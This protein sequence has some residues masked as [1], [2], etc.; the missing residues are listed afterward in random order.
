MNKN[1]YK[2]FGFVNIVTFPCLLIVSN[3]YIKKY[4]KNEIYL[5]GC[6]CKN[7]EYCENCG[8]T[9]SGYGYD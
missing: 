4:G 9:I 3:N 5:K 6:N 8:G 2:L 7:N 1:L